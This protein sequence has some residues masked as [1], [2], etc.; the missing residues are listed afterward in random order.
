MVQPLAAATPGPGPVV[1]N[2]I[3]KA[4]RNFAPVVGELLGICLFWFPGFARSGFDFYNPR[5][6][7]VRL[8]ERA[9]EQRR[10]P[11][12]STL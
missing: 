9:E 3:Y 8:I 4:F 7:L 2:S 10:K 5:D 12:Q 11:K 1:N 6:R